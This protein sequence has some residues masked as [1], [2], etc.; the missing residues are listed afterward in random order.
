MKHYDQIGQEQF[1]CQEY[2]Q[3]PYGS[4]HIRLGQRIPGGRANGMLPGEFDPAQLAIGTS[5]E[6]E[7]TRD[8]RLA[9][10]IAM[11]HLAEDPNYYRKLALVHLDGAQLGGFRED[12]IGTVGVIMGKEKATKFLDD[13]EALVEQ[14]AAVGAQKKVKPMVVGSMAI[15][16]IGLLLGGVA[17]VVAM[18]R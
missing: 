15:G 1:V 5:V 16:G 18:R 9:R 13:F 6:M 17:L 3:V 7:H 14:K 8:V 2:R 11:D 10:E 12:F 4:Q